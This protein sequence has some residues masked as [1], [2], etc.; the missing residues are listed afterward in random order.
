MIEDNGQRL[1]KGETLMER[2]AERGY[3]KPAMAE[4]AETSGGSLTNG[5]TKGEGTTAGALWLTS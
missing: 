1:E 2:N 4:R 5:A 3:G